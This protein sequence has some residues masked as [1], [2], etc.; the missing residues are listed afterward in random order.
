MQYQLIRQPAK[1]QTCWQKMPFI[2]SVRHI[3][4]PFQS[5][6]PSLDAC[7]AITRTADIEDDI[8]RDRETFRERLNTLRGDWRSYF[9]RVSDA[10]ELHA[11]LKG[12]P[13]LPLL[14]RAL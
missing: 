5:L 10:I 11:E 8:V 4:E 1:E 7:Y 9:S 13:A 6:D 14:V 2:T 3:G 12:Q